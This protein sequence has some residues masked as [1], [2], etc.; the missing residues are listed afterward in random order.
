MTFRTILGIRY[1]DGSLDELLTEARKGGLIVVPAGPALAEMRQ[2]NDYRHAVETATFAISDSSYM[3]LLWF[4]R[5]G[6]WLHRISGLQ[7][8]R[9]LIQDPPFRRKGATYWVMP[10]P[11][12]T[13]CN[14]AWLATAGI[15]VAEDQCYLAPKYSPGQIVDPELVRKIEEKRPEYVVINIGGGIQEVLGSYLME[16][17]SYRPTIVCTGAAIAFLSGRQSRIHPMVD[18]LMLGWFARCLHEPKR[19]IPR[20]LRAFRLFWILM[21][22]A[23]RSVASDAT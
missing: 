11:E 8:L 6:E 12:D 7:F 23:D 13:R 4:L 20:Y 14:V 9:A 10:S 1:F 19:F 15:E 17:L 22:Y 2:N 16:S 5:T 21:Q 3:V 18:T